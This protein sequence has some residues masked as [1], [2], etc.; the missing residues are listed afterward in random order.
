[1]SFDDPEFPQ[2]LTIILFH[3]TF[4]NIQGEAALRS[5]FEIDIF[6]HI[7]EEFSASPKILNPER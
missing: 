2:L 3:L 5:Y 7:K 6:Y 1:M 4:L